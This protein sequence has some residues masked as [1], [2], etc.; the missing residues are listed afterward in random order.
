MEEAVEIGDKYNETDN[1]SPR[2]I[3]SDPLCG[4]WKRIQKLSS[5]E[6]CPYLIEDDQPPSCDMRAASRK[7][8]GRPAGGAAAKRARVDVEVHEG[9]EIAGVD[10][11][12][13]NPEALQKTLRAIL[14]AGPAGVTG[15]VH[16]LQ[17]CDDGPS[18]AAMAEVDL[19]IME[20]A[21]MAGVDMDKM[22]DEGGN[23]GGG[24]ESP[25]F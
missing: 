14:S 22:G 13:D 21:A 25:E 10:L 2:Y 18:D 23:P 1:E 11:D 12:F 16:G 3:W 15:V 19:G 5:F 24:R 17:A 7:R 4:Y 6:E 8:A 9:W 20:G